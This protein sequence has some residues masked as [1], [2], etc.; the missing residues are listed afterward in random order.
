M[1]TVTTVALLL[2]AGCTGARGAAESPFDQVDGLI[3]GDVADELRSTLTEAMERSGSSGAIAG[4]W[5]PWSGS[6]EVA[7][8][9]TTP[10][11]D[12]PV[13][14][15]M[16]F[17]AGLITTGMACTV[18]LR[19]VDEGKVQLN[20]Q[21]G[22]VVGVPGLDGITFAQLCQQTSGL[23]DYYGPI[24]RYLISNPERVWPAAELLASGLARDR[25]G[26][27]GEKW[28]YSRTATI[29]LGIAL[30]EATNTEFAELLARYVSGPLDLGG[31]ALPSPTDVE[32]PGAAAAGLVA[33]PGG[34][35]RCTT[36]SDVSNLSSSAG[37][38]AFGAISNLEDLRV[39]SRALAT[40]VLLSEQ[41]ASAQWATVPRGTSAESWES[42][43][44]GASEFGPMRGIASEIPG[45]LTAAYA[46]PETGLTVVVALN[47]STA[48]VDFVRRT[49][50]ALA[51][52]GSKADAAE[53]REMPLVELPWSVEQMLEAMR[54]QGVCE[55]SAA[56]E[57][58]ES[59]G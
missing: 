24:R 18:L 59:E 26:E 23:G 34:E 35:S 3:G 38:A 53:G 12:T 27:P 52:I 16:S 30:E 14:T 51:S 28:S 36:L 21:V 5:A 2:I 33:T 42:Y 20:Q 41:S 48:G 54:E 15:D 56:D 45:S 49:A 43:G 7:V 11:G 39:W 44:L 47:N 10:D 32:L 1:A 22:P 4:V 8:G 25:A 31:T 37:Y 6:W 46:D 50:L 17:R 58:D 40:G 55:P 13:S 29:L 19:L 57:S 9:T